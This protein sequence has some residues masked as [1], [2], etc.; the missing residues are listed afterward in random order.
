MSSPRHG[1]AEEEGLQRSLVWAVAAAVWTIPMAGELLFKPWYNE[2]AVP[3][4]YR[5]TLQ[6]LV[7]I[8]GPCCLWAAFTPMILGS[9][10]RLRRWM[11]RHPQ[12]F[13]AGVAY[14]AFYARRRLIL[15]PEEEFAMEHRTKK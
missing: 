14:F 1:A 5:H 15:S 12:W 13:A 8:V 3:P 4:S 6:P 7:L 11:T 9:Q 10:R 2:V